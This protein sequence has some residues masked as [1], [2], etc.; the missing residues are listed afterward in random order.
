MTQS[1]QTSTNNLPEVMELVVAFRGNGFIVIQCESTKLMDHIN[2]I[3][4][5]MQRYFE[6]RTPEF[7]MMN[8]LCGPADFR[9]DLV[10]GVYT[11]RAHPTTTETYQK[12]LIELLNRQTNAAEKI[13]GECSTGEDWK[14]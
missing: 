1:N 8:G 5:A 11:R 3:R 13:A 14:G 2:L 6:T 10:D 7:I 12:T 9:I 4:G